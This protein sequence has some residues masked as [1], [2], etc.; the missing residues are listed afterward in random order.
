MVLMAKKGWLVIRYPIEAEDDNEGYLETVARYRSV[1]DH[2]TS[3]QRID[4]E[5]EGPQ[6][7]RKP[8]G[9]LSRQDRGEGLQKEE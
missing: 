1:W 6:R 8:G 5:W 3:E 2:L 7:P 4:V 9:F